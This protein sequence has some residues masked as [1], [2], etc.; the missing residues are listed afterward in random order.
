M[1][2]A[3]W[4]PDFPTL[5]GFFE[6]IESGKSIKASGTSNY[7]SLNDPIVNDAIDQSA[8]TSDTTKLTT[9]GH[10]INHGVMNDA[11]NLPY[12]WDSAYYYRNP[13]LTN[14]YLTPGTGFYY[15]YVNIGVSDGK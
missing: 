15:D 6:T 14:V 1:A 4:G 5:N 9:L 3:A 10:T 7:A 8:Q 11:V 13:R 2:Q 12:L